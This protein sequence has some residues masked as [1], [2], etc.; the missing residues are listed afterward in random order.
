MQKLTGFLVKE[1]VLNSLH[2]SF[3]GSICFYL[4]LVYLYFMLTYFNTDDKEF[5]PD[6]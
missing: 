2:G 4:I 5:D 3:F 6:S 1:D